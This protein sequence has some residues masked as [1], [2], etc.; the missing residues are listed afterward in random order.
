MRSPLLEALRLSPDEWQHCRLAAREMSL[1][2]GSRV[3][4][5]QVALEYVRARSLEPL[6]LPPLRDSA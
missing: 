6:P 4:P 5:A 2:T 3:E 1:A